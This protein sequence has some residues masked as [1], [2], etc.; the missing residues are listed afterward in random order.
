VDGWWEVLQD[1]STCTLKCGGGT[2]TQHRKCHAP[3]S[4]EGK[5]CIGEPI[6]TKSCNTEPCPPDV[7][8][9]ESEEDLPLK[10][11]MM[12]VSDRP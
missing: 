2:Q 1:W 6:I 3:T 10:V 5:P 7:E 4:N 9:S 11:E 8:D 12:K